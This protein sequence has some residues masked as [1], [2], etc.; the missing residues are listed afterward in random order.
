[1]HR[2]IFRSFPKTIRLY[3]NEDHLQHAMRLLPGLE[4]QIWHCGPWDLREMKAA[5]GKNMIVMGKHPSAQDAPSG[6]AP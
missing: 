5:V 6:N 2:E 4:A 1:M 3:H